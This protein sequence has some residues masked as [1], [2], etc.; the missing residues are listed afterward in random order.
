MY[1][2]GTEPVSKDLVRAYMWYAL[3]ASDEDARLTGVR[4]EFAESLMPEQ[5]AAGN[6]LAAEWRPDVCEMPF[7]PQAIF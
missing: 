2:W 4:D 1:R 6:E 7:G 3:A 5:I